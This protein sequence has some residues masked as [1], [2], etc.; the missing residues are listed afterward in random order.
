MTDI[1]VDGMNSQGT[2]AGAFE[3]DDAVSW[4]YLHDLSAE[5]GGKIVGA[6]QVYR[7]VPDFVESDVQIRWYDDETKVGVFIKG[8][9][10]AHFDLVSGWG[11]PGSYSGGRPNA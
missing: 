6:V 2:Y 5:P 8:Q 7:G 3:A 9:L 10:G 11:L 4:F 1:F